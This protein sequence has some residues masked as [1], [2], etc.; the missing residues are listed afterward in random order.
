MMKPALAAALLI[1]AASAHARTATLSI[2][3]VALPLARLESVQATFGDDAELVL[4]AKTLDAPALGYGFA[5]LRWRCDFTREQTG[6]LHCRG[7]LRARD[8]G[9]ATLAATW[10]DG[11]LDL[12]LSKGE[13]EL[14]FAL[15]EP[16][17]LR[18]IHLPA[19]WLQPLLAAR[20]P[21]G[22]LTAGTL[23]TRLEFGETSA[24]GLALGGPLALSQIGLDSADGRIATASLDAQGRL[25]L[26]FDDAA[27]GVNLA[28]QLHGGEWLAGP[29]YVALPES[30]I[31]FALAMRSGDDGAWS[32][33]RFAWKDDG[34]LELEASG[35]LDF[36]AAHGPAFIASTT[37]AAAP[38]STA[39]NAPRALDVSADA[40]LVALDAEATMPS[41]AT[42]TPRYFEVLLRTLGLEDMA[43]DGAAKVAVAR[44]AGVWQ[45]VQV[46]LDATQVRE[47][48]FGFEG[49]SGNVAW[50][51][52]APVE[53]TVR[54]Q[55]ARVHEVAFGQAR[56]PLRS[57]QG[58]VAL[59]QPLRVDLLGGQLALTRFAWRPGVLDAALALHGI[60]LQRL[61]QAL[62]W[63]AFTGTLA[64]ELPALH[65]ADGVLAFDGG[66]QLALF[67]GRIDV[68]DL[69]LER[70]FG[71]AP[72]LAANVAIADLDL[73]PLT[74]A[75]GFG[76]ISGR[77]DGRIDALRVVDWQPVAFDADLHT[78][79]K[80]KEAR[81]ISQRAV[82]DLS[83]V[84][85][86]G[87]VA[88]L[89]AQVLKVFETFAYA[90]IGLKCQL[91]N[92]VCEMGGL[93]SSQGGYTIVEGSG[94]PRITVVGHQHRVD[95]PVLVARLKAATEGQVPIVD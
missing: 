64:G 54:W 3:R 92:D 29:L 83:S 36:A 65:Y 79:G 17:T 18:G 27:T 94:L 60:Q 35:A 86:A 67:D 24:R 95:W 14:G 20:W 57:E 23:D 63:P 5:D 45:R 16:M 85:G 2:E 76:E 10:K 12:A 75:L 4:T 11:A 58:G 50:S 7:P 81:R 48:R 31:D 28:L 69:V 74:G 47:S 1:A 32:L 53:S 39:S 22:K 56:L 88:G 43:L 89:Q 73:K 61:S 15:A 33:Q 46:D 66:L 13:G 70:P 84:G 72:T 52:A 62:G 68:A 77:L 9:S 90:R 26:A 93:D 78:D 80:A 19:T 49:L 8:A 34:V 38:P 87:V 51:A 21:A 30:P 44:K 41:L 55:S 82:Q 6:A 59:T 40:T 37:S 42:A 91:A 25:D 71:V